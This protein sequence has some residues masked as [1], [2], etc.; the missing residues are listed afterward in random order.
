MLNIYLP[1]NHIQTIKDTFDKPTKANCLKLFTLQ[2]SLKHQYHLELLY[3]PSF[4]SNIDRDI[5]LR[6]WFNWLNFNDVQILERDEIINSNVIT[7]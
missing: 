7:K 4:E 2:N 5:Y 1:K 6:D 3:V